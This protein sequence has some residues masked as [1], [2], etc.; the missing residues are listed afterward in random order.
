MNGGNLDRKTIVRQ[1]E[2]DLPGLKNEIRNLKRF[3]QKIR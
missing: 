3:F 1:G 2:G